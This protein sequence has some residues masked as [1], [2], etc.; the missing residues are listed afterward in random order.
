[1]SDHMQRKIMEAA[2]KRHIEKNTIAIKLLFH[3]QGEPC[4]G[5]TEAAGWDLYASMKD[6][7]EIT[8]M[9]SAVAK[10]DTGV[11]IQLPRG[12]EAQ[13]RSRSGLAFKHG[14]VVLNG[15]GTIDADYRGEIGVLLINHGQEPVTIR[16][17]DRIA[18]MVIA[19]V[20][21]N[22]LRLVDELDDTQRSDGGFGSTGK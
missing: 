18:Q 21:M 22:D 9:P 17:G 2:F 11:C 16:R 4:R 8:L 7:S 6:V 14:V 1:M 20:C 13:I 15:V 19:D 12:K 10:I 3:C 5:S